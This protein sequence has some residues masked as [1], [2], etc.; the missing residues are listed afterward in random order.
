MDRI[1]TSVMLP[2]KLVPEMDAAREIIGVSKS[3]FM[4]VAL[5]FYLVNNSILQDVPQ[6]RR[7]H[8]LQVQESFQKL[9]DKALENA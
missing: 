2:K 8:I 5:S 7:K 3:D 1:K 4:A 6:K 9:I